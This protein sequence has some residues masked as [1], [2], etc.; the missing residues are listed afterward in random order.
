[1]LLYNADS[2]LSLG[3]FRRVSFK[4]SLSVYLA[5]CLLESGFLFFYL[6]CSLLSDSPFD[7]FFPSICYSIRTRLHSI[8]I[9]CLDLLP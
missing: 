7:S 6:L 3:L 1:M 2:C 9:P 4:V 5:G 8:S